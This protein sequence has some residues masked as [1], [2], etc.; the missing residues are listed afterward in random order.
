MTTT[1]YRFLFDFLNCPLSEEAWQQELRPLFP[2][3]LQR[4]F[5]VVPP[6]QE[7]Q[8]LPS[9]GQISEALQGQL[10]TQGMKYTPALDPSQP[11]R[12]IQQRLAHNTLWHKLLAEHLKK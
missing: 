11:S 7:T 4:P 5:S 8:A 10:V 1:P 2:K 3:R 9:M 6:S 12:E